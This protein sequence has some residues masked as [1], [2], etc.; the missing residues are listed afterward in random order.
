MRL[1]ANERRATDNQ[2][3]LHDG[4]GGNGG[5]DRQQAVAAESGSEGRAEEEKHLQ[6]E[7]SLFHTALLQA[8]HLLLP[9]QGLYLVSL[10]FVCFCVVVI[11]VDWP[12][13]TPRSIEGTLHIASQ[14]DDPLRAWK[15]RLFGLPQI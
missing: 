5:N 1:K 6:R 4:R 2:D 8:A 10:S 7:G 12:R 11:F 9:L 14:P 13:N 15:V 3:Q